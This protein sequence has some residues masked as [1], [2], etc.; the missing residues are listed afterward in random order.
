MPPGRCVTESEREKLL[1]LLRWYRVGCVCL[2]EFEVSNWGCRYSRFLTAL[3][4][5]YSKWIVT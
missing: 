3:Q 2:R 1:I 5:R 4:H